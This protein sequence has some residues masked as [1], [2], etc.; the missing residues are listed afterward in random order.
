MDRDVHGEAQSSL[1]KL[2]RSR[3]LASLVVICSIGLAA[4]LVVDTYRQYQAKLLECHSIV[5]NA[6]KLSLQQTTEFLRQS[7]A[8]L[9]QLTD[10]A[11]MRARVVT[12]CAD[13]LQDIKR[14]QPV[15]INLVVLDSSGQ[16]L[17]E[18]LAESQGRTPDSDLASTFQHLAG[19]DKL[20]F[21][22]P[23]QDSASYR[24]ISRLLYPFKDGSGKPAGALAL[25]IDLLHLDLMG[26]SK[27]RQPDLIAGIVNADRTIVA[28]SQDGLLRIGQSAN[29]A[30]SE[31]I[32]REREGTASGM[33]FL[34]INRLFSYGPV[35]DSDW[36]VFANINIDDAM[37]PMFRLALERLAEIVVLMLTAAAA[38]AMLWRKMP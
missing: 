10:D 29:S 18:S 4:A 35:P 19:P 21:G 1:T 6:R 27:A 23:V 26:P 20:T 9:M 5:N 15:F 8:L 16:V 17:C 2:A 11:S 34:G 24:W 22:K 31:R 14:T 25:S 28:R 30:V 38:L 36:I 32:V 37:K 33:D 3:R 12:R 7:K 13:V